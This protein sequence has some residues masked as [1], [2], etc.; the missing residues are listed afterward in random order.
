MPP[1]PSD[2]ANDWLTAEFRLMGR[3]LMGLDL[4]ARLAPHTS[5]TLVLTAD[6]T[7]NRLSLC[8]H[9]CNTIVL[10]DLEGDAHVSD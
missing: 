9:T 7:T 8:C 5:H 2:I 10:H 6:P 4:Y 1:T 3:K